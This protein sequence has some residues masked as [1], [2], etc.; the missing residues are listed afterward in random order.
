MKRL[1]EARLK[2]CRH[3]TYSNF[4]SNLTIELFAIKT[5]PNPPS[6][7]EHCVH[8]TWESNK[9]FYSHPKLKICLTPVHKGRVFGIKVKKMRVIQ[10]GAAGI[11]RGL[12]ILS[13]LM[14]VWH[15]CKHKC[16][17]EA[18]II[19]FSEQWSISHHFSKQECHSLQQFQPS[20]CEFLSS[21]GPK[22]NNTCYPACHQPFPTVSV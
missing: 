2:E 6:F 20:K 13:T 1:S 15:A 16:S 9:P 3:C 5:P 22:K 17:W 11:R 8:L 7:E 4:T 12:Y 10:S 18:K 21:E 14:R 19:S